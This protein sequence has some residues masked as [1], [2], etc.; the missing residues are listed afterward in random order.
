MD[1]IK[2]FDQVRKHIKTK[3]GKELAKEFRKHL[4]RHERT[5]Q[6]YGTYFMDTMDGMPPEDSARDLGLI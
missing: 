4:K 1:L 2:E 5:D 6:K 3:E